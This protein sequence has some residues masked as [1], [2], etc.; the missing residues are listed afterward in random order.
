MRIFTFADV[1][2]FLKRIL[3]L[4]DAEKA[5]NITFLF[6]GI[7]AKLGLV[8]LFGSSKKNPVNILGLNFKNSLGV[9][10]GFD[11]N[12]DYLTTWEQ[13]GFGFVEVGTVTPKPQ[14]GNP[15]PRLFR[16]PKNESL[17]NRM[18]F[19]NKGLDFMVA[20]LKNYNGDLTIGCN[21]G[22]NKNT[23]NVLA[24]EDYLACFKGLYPYANYF[25]VNVSSPNTKDL[26]TLQKHEELTK[27]LNPLLAYRHTVSQ[28]MGK[29]P[30]LV[31]LSPDMEKDEFKNSV[32]FLN[33]LDIQGLV[34]TN[35]TI[36]RNILQVNGEKRG[37]ENG[38]LSGKVLFEESNG[39]L[40]LAKQYMPNKTIIG[41]GG[42]DS[43][44]RAKEKLECGADAIQIYSGLVFKGP[45]LVQ[46]I[47]KIMN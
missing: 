27:I 17:I 6:A 45:K 1:Y 22:K 32:K 11:K 47:L 20:K 24:F 30:I 41:V 35:T 5:H 43:A 29:K 18:G 7:A 33:E 8:R 14:E 21:I 4:L 38:G 10:A 34:L 16:L 9:A 26:R 3:F 36:K 2:T 13:M 40:R 39:W 19:N 25:T 23:P 12:A 42:I 31:K 46:D 15:K 44:K 37:N 28:K